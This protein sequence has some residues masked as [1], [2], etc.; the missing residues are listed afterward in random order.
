LVYKNKMFEIDM[1][2]IGIILLV[3][4]IFPLKKDL[5]QLVTNLFPTGGCHFKLEKPN[6]VS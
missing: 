4:E 2:D 6:L 1:S 3:T 5:D